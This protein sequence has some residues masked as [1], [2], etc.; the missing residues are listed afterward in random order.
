MGRASLVVLLAALGL[1]AVARADGL[2][3]WKNEQI[4]I[5]EPEQKALIV[6]DEGV[7]DLVLSVKFEGAPE[8]FGWIVPLP[9][10]MSTCSRS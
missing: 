1:A 4:D 3:V 9:R 2:F 7:E 10:R 5:H 6:F 8:E